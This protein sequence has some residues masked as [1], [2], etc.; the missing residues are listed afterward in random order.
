[1]WDSENYSCAYD[2]VL[3]VLLSIWMQN[4]SA[5]KKHFADMNRTMKML[6]AGFHHTNEE[7]E[8]LESARN[9]IRQVLHQRSPTL[10][11]YGQAGTPISEVTEHLLRSDNIIASTWLMCMDCKHKTNMEDDLQ[12][13]MIQCPDDWDCT[14]SQCLQQKLQH[15]HPR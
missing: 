11:L 9:K 7:Q 4:P 15:R 1:M 6:T 5:W 2:S 13:C 14:M 8:T 3:T 10:F 12:T